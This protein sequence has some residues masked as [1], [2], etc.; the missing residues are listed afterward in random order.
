MLLAYMTNKD[1]G[2]GAMASSWLDGHCSAQS[3]TPSQI[4]QVPGG[5][6]G[7]L[8]VLTSK[9][10]ITAPTATSAL[11]F[12]LPAIMGKLTPGGSLPTSIPHDVMGF[13]GGAKDMLMGSVG[14]AAGAATAGAYAAGNAAKSA[15]VV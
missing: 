11:S 2:L 1:T 3:A 7:L 9:L 12:P 8:G 6:G 13:I 14:A 4:E 10:G 15:G 5:A